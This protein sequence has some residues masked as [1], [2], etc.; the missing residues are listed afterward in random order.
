MFCTDLSENSWNFSLDPQLF[1][2]DI[3]DLLL[4]AVDEQLDKLQVSDDDENLCF[5]LML[6]FNFFFF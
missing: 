4:N 1:K 2:V 6:H 5:K 3:C